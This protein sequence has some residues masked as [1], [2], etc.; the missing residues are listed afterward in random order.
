VNPTAGGG[1][2]A[3][4]RSG[5]PAAGYAE[6]LDLYKG[7]TQETHNEDQFLDVLIVRQSIQ[8]CPVK[9]ARKEFARSVRHP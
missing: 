1:L 6:S 4:W 7:T 3:D 2:A 5:S 8:R 9:P